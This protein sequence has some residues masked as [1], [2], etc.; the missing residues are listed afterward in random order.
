MLV[1]LMYLKL[2]VIQLQR[3]LLFN[4]F[5]LAAVEFMLRLLQLQRME[6]FAS[7]FCTSPEKISLV[8]KSQKSAGFPSTR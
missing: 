1:C 5:I 3:Y 6:M 2:F 7:R 4:L 8:M